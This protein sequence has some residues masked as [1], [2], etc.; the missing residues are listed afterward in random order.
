MSLELNKNASFVVYARP[1]TASDRYFEGL[2]Q[3]LQDALDQGLVLV[4][5]Q[6]VFLLGHYRTLIRKLLTGTPPAYPSV[7]TDE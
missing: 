5:R 2:Q 1:I 7:A 4:E 3:E 6:E